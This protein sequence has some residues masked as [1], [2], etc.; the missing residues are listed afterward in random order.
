MSVKSLQNFAEGM[1]SF[2]ETLSMRTIILLNFRQNIII[3][4]TIGKKTVWNKSDT[5]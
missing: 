4:M 3:E 5:L 1:D 2:L